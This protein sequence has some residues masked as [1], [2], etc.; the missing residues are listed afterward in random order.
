MSRTSHQPD[1]A[2]LVVAAV[3]T[4]SSFELAWAG[5]LSYQCVIT[6]EINLQDDGKLRPYQ[7][8]IALNKRFSIDRRNGAIV[9]PEG[10]PWTFQDSTAS[11]LAAGNGGNA[12]V[13]TYT[14]PSAGG[15]VHFTVIRVE[16]FNPN[17]LKPFVAISSGTVHSGL[18]E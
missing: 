13:A 14:A 10:V 17:R 18:C 4:L 5:L 9:G 7:R 16:E 12:F 3:L 11:L 6:T 2:R 1:L 8:P 15:G